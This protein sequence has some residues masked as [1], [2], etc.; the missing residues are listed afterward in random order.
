MSKESNKDLGVDAI[1]IAYCL[2]HWV[3]DFIPKFKLYSFVGFYQT[4]QHIYTSKYI[5]LYINKT[6]KK[7]NYI[8]ISVAEKK[9]NNN[10]IIIKV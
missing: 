5:Y 7:T 3:I 10:V 2:S 4:N 9:T 8:S 6:K 1:A